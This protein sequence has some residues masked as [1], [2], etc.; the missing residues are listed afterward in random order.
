MKKVLFTLFQFLAFVIVAQDIPD[1]PKGYIEIKEGEQKPVNYISEGKDEIYFIMPEDPLQQTRDVPKKAL[2]G[3][4][5]PELSDVVFLRNSS[6]EIEYSGVVEVPGLSKKEIFQMARIWF[7]EYY[8][9]SD[10]VLELADLEAGILIGTGW[11]EMINYNFWLGGNTVHFYSTVKIRIKEGRYKFWISEFRYQQYG[12]D[13]K[14]TFGS[15]RSLES[16]N[17]ESPNWKIFK[18]IKADIVNSI[19]KMYWS[20]NSFPARQAEEGKW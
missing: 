19:I 12:S 13:G 11:K 15:P 16:S 8:M 1:I 20:L 5:T 9:S 7:A 2:K 17:L 4:G 3:F 18:K 10:E 6:G 14:A